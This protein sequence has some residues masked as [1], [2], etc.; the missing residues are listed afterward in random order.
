MSCSRLTDTRR[1][2]GLVLT[3]V[4]R[5]KN[6][7]RLYIIDVTRR[8]DDRIFRLGLFLNSNKFILKKKKKLIEAQ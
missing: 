4:N 6:F 8:S 5:C 3:L 2:D 1:I 7:I